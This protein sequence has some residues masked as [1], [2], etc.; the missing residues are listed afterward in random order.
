MQSSLV[1]GVPVSVS[2]SVLTLESG[3]AWGL[4]ERAIRGNT[5]LHKNKKYRNHKQECLN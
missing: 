4:G 2:L 3:Q 5:G 1:P